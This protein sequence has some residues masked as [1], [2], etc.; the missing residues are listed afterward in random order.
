MDDGTLQTNDFLVAGQVK[1]KM[2]YNKYYCYD[3]DPNSVLF[4]KTIG[5]KKGSIDGL[6]ANKKKLFKAEQF[7]TS[8]IK[9]QPAFEIIYRMLLKDLNLGHLQAE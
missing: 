3:K 6:E 1:Q 2:N 5:N 8:K 7:L 9:S 4:T